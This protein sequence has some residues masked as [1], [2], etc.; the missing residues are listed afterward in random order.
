MATENSDVFNP[1][2]PSV[3]FHIETSHWFYFARE[4]TGSYMKFNTMLNWVKDTKSKDS[5]L[6]VGV[7]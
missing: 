7:P 3:A 5:L 6:W 2:Q 1:F 4:M